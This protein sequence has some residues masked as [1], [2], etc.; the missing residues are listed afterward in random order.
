L[1][2]NK[3]EPVSKLEIKK[4]E[5]HIEHNRHP[6]IRNSSAI[7]KSSKMVVNETDESIDVEATETAII[8]PLDFVFKSVNKRF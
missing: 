1:H 3:I 6:I 8:S 2:S 4:L 7:F 5:K